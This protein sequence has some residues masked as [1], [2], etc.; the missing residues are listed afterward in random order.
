LARI[1][2]VAGQ[3]PVKKTL[4]NEYEIRKRNTL[5][6]FHLNDPVYRKLVETVDVLDAEK[7]KRFPAVF[8]SHKSFRKKIAAQRKKLHA[9]DPVYKETLSAT[10]RANRALE[11]YLVEQN[12]AINQGPATGRKAAL[13]RSR[14]KHR[15]DPA[16]QKLTAVAEAAQR[17][18]EADYPQ[19]FVSDDAIKQERAEARKAL[20]NDPAYKAITQKR[21]AA[22]RDQQDYLHNRDKELGRLKQRLDAAKQK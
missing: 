2:K 19:L 10:H 6:R 16:Y 21:A 7:V 15:N 12:L 11:A 18:L 9:E 14:Q 4:A 5:A 17:K 1:Q 13:E 3:F 20:K 8:S 22:Y